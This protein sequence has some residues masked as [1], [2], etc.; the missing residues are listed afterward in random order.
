MYGHVHVRADADLP[1]AVEA[2]EFIVW[3]I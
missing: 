2:L 3:Q 1:L